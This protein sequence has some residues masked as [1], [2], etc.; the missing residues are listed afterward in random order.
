MSSP[1]GSSVPTATTVAIYDRV[2]NASIERIWENVM[3]WEHL[4]WLHSGSFAAIE[5]EHA[6]EQ[7]WRASVEVGP[8][9]HSAAAR[10][11]VCLDRP[12]SRYTTSTLEGVGAGTKIVTSL[13]PVDAGSTAIKV[14]FIVADIAEEDV[15]GVGAIYLALYRQLW[16]EDETM[17][18]RRQSFLDARAENVREVPDA[19]STLSL[20]QEADL[21]KRLPIVTT[22]GARTVRVVELG[23]ELVAYD[24]TC[25]H[26][27]GPL[28]EAALDDASVVC[29]WHGYRFDIRTRDGRDGCKL[30][31]A[32]APRVE[33]DPISGEVRLSAV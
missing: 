25:P 28:E 33:I 11:E 13:D 27:G 31:L 2:I 23:G 4:P 30:R 17:M 6:D 26:L 10:V 8:R 18:R 12:H 15:D 16:D 1:S 29:P 24:A 21:R 19:A 14:E 7:G 22:F 9:G 32:A 20:G 5:L 3:D